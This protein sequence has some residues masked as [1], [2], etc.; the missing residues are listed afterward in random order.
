MENYK[1]KNSWMLEEALWQTNVATSTEA[2]KI[3]LQLCI[4]YAQIIAF[5]HGENRFMCDANNLAKLASQY[6]LT[7]DFR[8]V[9]GD[10]DHLQKAG[11][12]CPSWFAKDLDFVAP[13]TDKVSKMQ[14]KFFWFTK[15]AC[16]ANLK[17]LQ[18]KSDIWKI[19]DVC[20]L[21]L[22]EDPKTGEVMDEN[23]ER[24]V[25][26]LKSVHT[27]CKRLDPMRRPD[28]MEVLSSY[29][30]VQKELYEIRE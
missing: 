30:M 7:D 17:E 2:T 29:L 28:A 20:M 13:E 23:S 9:V 15:K 6:L 10:V 19:P 8:L 22:S 3:R 5:L 11:Q 4:D 27:K 14:C 18:F 26:H 1:H 12:P 25:R 24:V 21:Y 16:A